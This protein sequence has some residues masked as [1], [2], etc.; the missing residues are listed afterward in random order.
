MPN[1]PT[2]THHWVSQ[3]FERPLYLPGLLLR[4][5]AVLQLGDHLSADQVRQIL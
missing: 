3:A 4:P 1:N 2:R 5:F